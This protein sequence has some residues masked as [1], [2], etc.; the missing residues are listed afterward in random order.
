MNAAT[1]VTKVADSIEHIAN[2]SVIAEYLVI[3][4]ISGL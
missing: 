1:L 2:V 4:K 3:L